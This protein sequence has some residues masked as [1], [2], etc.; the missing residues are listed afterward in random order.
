MSS[1]KTEPIKSNTTYKKMALAKL[2]QEFVDAKEQEKELKAVLTGSKVELSARVLAKGKK[3]GKT[4][5]SFELTAG[6]Y[7]AKMEARVSIAVDN[8]VAVK[9]FNKKKIDDFE[10]TSTIEVRNGID[11]SKIPAKLLK[12]VNKYFSITVHKS[13]S[14]EVLKSKFESGDIGPKDYKACVNETVTYALKVK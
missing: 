8:D 13:V 1:K 3:C 6:S 9:I 7:N 11:P 14:K 5:K 4:M 10:V 12:D 2:A